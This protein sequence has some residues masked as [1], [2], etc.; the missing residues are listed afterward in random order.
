[1]AG[2]S[3][4]PVNT[5]SIAFDDPAFNEAAF[6]QKVADRYRTNHHCRPRRQ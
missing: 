5:C 4:D 6:A 2:Q 1:M 3:A